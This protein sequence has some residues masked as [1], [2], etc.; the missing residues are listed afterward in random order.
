MALFVAEEL[1]QEEEE[2][3]KGESLLSVL[4]WDL[5]PSVRLEAVSVA[6]QLE[7][8]EGFEILRLLSRD[9]NPEVKLRVAQAAR[10]LE[11]IEGA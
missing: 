2:R 1:N 5:D 11:G 7:N 6:G 8:R 3:K 10:D 9:S 4:A